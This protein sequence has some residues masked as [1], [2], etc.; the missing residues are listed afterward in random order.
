MRFACDRTGLFTATLILQRA[1]SPEE[2]LLIESHVLLL[3]FVKGMCF[4]EG[5]PCTI[6][7]T[8]EP[9]SPLDSKVPGAIAQICALITEI[10]DLGGTAQMVDIAQIDSNYESRHQ[11]SGNR[12]EH[13]DVC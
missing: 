8:F 9:I 2:R 6:D 3:D 7:I 13:D 10:I 4:H 5:H 11:P 12:P 1:I